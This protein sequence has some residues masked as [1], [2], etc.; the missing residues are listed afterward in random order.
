MMKVMEIV[1]LMSMPS[2]EAIFMSCSQ[3][4]WAR[5]RGVRVIM[6]VNT[7]IRMRVDDDDK[8]LHVRQA[9]DEFALSDRRG[10]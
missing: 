7:A 3:E 6:A 1:R 10:S 2:S 5:P 9:D 8:N 4:R